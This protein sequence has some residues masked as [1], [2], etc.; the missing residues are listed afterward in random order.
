MEM[1]LYSHV[2]HMVSSVSGE[3]AAGRDATDAL[4]AAFPAG[5][6]S[7]APKVRAMEIID[8]LETVRR[9]PYAGAIGYLSYSGDLDTCICI[10]TDRAQRRHRLRAGRRRRGRRLRAGARVRGDREQGRRLAARHR[11]RPHGV[12][13]PAAGAQLGVMAVLVFMI[14]NYDSFTYNLVQIFAEL[15]AEVIVARNDQIT[16]GRDRRGR[17]H[18]SGHLARPVHA[19]RGGHLD[20][21]HR[22]LR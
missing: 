12:R 21:R 11:A 3:L 16:R 10:R 5:T 6:V 18:P 8:E 1:E 17:A 13:R 19:A 2:I 22:S 7:G 4:K 20:G 9:G 15:G 14:D